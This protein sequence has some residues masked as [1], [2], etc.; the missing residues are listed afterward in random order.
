MKI[1]FLDDDSQRHAR[2]RARSI[3][4]VIHHVSTYEDAV[5][6][7][8]QKGPYDEVW[9]DHDLSEEAA[10]GQPKPGEKNGMDVVNFILA[11]PM[12]RQPQVVIIHS[13]NYVE[14]TKMQA[15]LEAVDI[16]VRRTYV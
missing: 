13:L 3:G 5:V 7:L 6:F 11:L 4:K 10:A 14:A 2:F 16:K 9:L 1:L 12:E 8:V 15:K